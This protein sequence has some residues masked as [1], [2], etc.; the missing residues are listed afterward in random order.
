MHANKHEK[1]KKK[2]KKKEKEEE[3]ASKGTN[4][5]MSFIYLSDMVSFV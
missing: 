1:K 5:L 3:E 2:K 4:T